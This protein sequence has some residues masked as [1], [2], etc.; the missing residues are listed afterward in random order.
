MRESSKTPTKHKRSLSFASNFPFYPSGTKTCV[1][2]ILR[3]RNQHMKRNHSSVKSFGKK[4]KTLAYLT[5]YIKMERRHALVL[6]RCIDQPWKRPTS[7]FIV[8]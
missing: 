2:M 4:A 3:S 5:K 8:K 1:F 6:S 7:T